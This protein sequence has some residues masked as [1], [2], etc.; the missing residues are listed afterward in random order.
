MKI[1]T[2]ILFVLLFVA[3]HGQSQTLQ[4]R[5]T[6]TT[7]SKPI[8]SVS[9]QVKGTPKG[10]RTDRKGEY[11]IT[12]KVSDVLVFSHIGMQTVEYSVKEG[13]AV[14]NVDLTPKIEELQE[15]VVKKK[16]P[17]T[18]KE[19]LAAY[20][21]NKRLIKTTFG[22]W[23][24]DRASF[25]MRIIDGEELIP[26]GT[27]FLYSLQ[28]LYPQM[29][30]F[31]SCDI[32]RRCPQVILPNRNPNS[33]PVIFD[34]DGFIFEDVPTYLSAIDIDRVAI[35]VGNGALSRY[36]P[37]GSGGVIVINTKGKTWMD[38]MGVKR[39]Y[40][41]TNLIDSIHGVFAKT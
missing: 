2:T 32:G 18:Q 1:T 10:V 28:N 36:G 40:D 13:D 29:R 7:A 37:Q 15:V 17:A 31:R 5:G 11:T 39:T 38:D 30:V 16:K 4:V 34:V 35:L 14:L 25:S 24:K 12:V 9:V 22:I 26:V 21:T 19:L 33:P 23:D 6:V 8:S 27:D 41:N 3:M 20:P